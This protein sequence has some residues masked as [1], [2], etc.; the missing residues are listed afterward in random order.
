[1]EHEL[2]EHRAAQAELD[3]LMGMEASAP[4]DLEHGPLIRGRLIR[5]ADDEH[6]LLL[7]M[8]HIV[9]DGWSMGVLVNE[10][11]ALYNAFLR[12][13]DD[14]LPELDIQY[15]DYAV[16][17]RQWIEGEVL[18]QQAAYWKTA[19]ADVP[20]L[21]ELPTDH[22]RPAQQDYAG[23]FA[24]VV[25]E[26]ELTA[27]LKELSRRHGATLFMTLLT[28][29]ATLLARL[30]GQ[31]DVV[32]GTPSANRGRAEIEHLIGFFVNTLAV[33]LNLSG[34]PSVSELFAQARLQTLAAQQHQDIPFEQVVELAHPVRSLA[35]SPLFQVMFAWQN[36]AEGGVELPGLEL[37]RLKSPPH[38]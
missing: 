13:E 24:E 18:Q 19:L 35:H 34:S 11:S 22:P 37:S 15:A 25:L 12:G 5:L 32:I 14:P 36:T 38:R 33:R 7:T 27:G 2:R 21:L 17:Q 6:A 3:R 10:L 4:F 9:S 20:A 28:A 26:E 16:W 23:A 30:S 8:H 29:W 31:Q 1:L